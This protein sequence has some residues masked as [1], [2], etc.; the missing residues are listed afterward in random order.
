MKK[1]ILTIIITLFTT[2]SFATTW[3][4]TEV[5]DPI[6]GESTKVQ[7]I[8]SYGSYIY[9]WPSKYDAV[10]WPLTSENYI[11]FNSTSGYAAFGHDF[12][13]ITEEEKERVTK[14]LKQNYDSENSPTT[15]IDKLTW[16]AKVYEA[17]GA[18][19]EF[20]IRYY[21]LLSY[22]TRNDD[23][24]SS[25]YRQEALSRIIPHLATAKPSTYRAQLYLV[26][27]FYSSLLETGEKDQYWDLAMKQDLGIEGPEEKKQAKEYLSTI[28]QEL[29]SEKYKGKYHLER[30]SIPR[31]GSLMKKNRI[32]ALALKDKELESEI[33]KLR[34]QP[35]ERYVK[36][37]A[38]LN[39]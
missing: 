9:G 7:S 13:S 18:D 28:L 1:T 39:R 37:R 34:T 20:V 11:W 35:I 29:K 6:S 21:C 3:H 22:L 8:G 33:E 2:S 32:K 4:E 14:F 15:H 5:F 36:R 25:P 31:K 26:A 38:K 27:G 24:A 12:E 30:D 17:R 23:E 16:L 19:P 10:Y